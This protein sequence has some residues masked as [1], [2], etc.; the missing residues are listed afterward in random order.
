MMVGGDLQREVTVAHA[1]VIADDTRLLQ[2]QDIDQAGADEGH[3]SGPWF[4]G[5]HAKEPVE[6]R[7]EAPLDVAISVGDGSDPGQRK[8]PREPLL[9]SLEGALGTTARLR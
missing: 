4:A 2:A 6:R 5:G 9:P 8:L 3:E 1:I 7:Q